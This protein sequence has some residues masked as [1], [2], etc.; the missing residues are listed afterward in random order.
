MIDKV[1]TNLVYLF[2][3]KNTCAYTQKDEYFAT[4]EYNRL[5]EIIAG[6]ASE[7]NKNLRKSIIDSFEKDIT[8]KNFNDLSLFDWEDRCFTFSLNIIEDKELY[9]ISLYLSILIPYYV[10]YYYFVKVFLYL[11]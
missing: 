9:T 8:L 2:Y 5:K 4:E 10:I 11:L 7:E 3:P 6:F 1:L